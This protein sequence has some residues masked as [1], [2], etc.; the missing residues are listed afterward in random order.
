MITLPDLQIISA[1]AL[2]RSS[3][4]KGI[5]G[6]P[7]ALI[8]GKP[9]G[10]LLILA[11]SG[12]GDALMF[13]PALRLL[14]S[15]WPD[16]QIDMLT[17]FK[18]TADLYKRNPD[19]SNV[20]YWNFLKEN[21]FKSLQFVLSLHKKYLY[22]I[23]A[24][25]ANRWPYAVISR[26]ISAK[27]RLGHTYLHVDKKEL[28]FLNNYRI[29]E[30]DSLH[31]SEENIRL[32]AYLG[33]PVPELLPPLQIHLNQQD[34]L[35][36][37]TWISQHTG[38]IQNRRL[39]GIH[40]GSAIFKNQINKRWD[41]RKYAQ[42]AARLILEQHAF[43]LLFGGPEELELNQQIMAELKA[44]QADHAALIVQMPDIM[45]SIAL[46]QQCALFLS[47]DSGLMHI[48]AALQIP[49]ISIFGYTSHIHTAPWMNTKAVIIRRDLE[50][51]PCFYFSPK[52]A[53]CQFAGSP[54]EFH[55]IRGIGPDDIYSQAV[56]MLQQG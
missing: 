16:L 52:P 11:M 15:A 9:R 23:T 5:P 45:G 43:I 13:S 31:N 4:E 6:I 39:V 35:S 47:N 20:L 49:L 28:N 42:V 46:M 2:H 32:A 30:D 14:R 24:F 25:P 26:L 17:M 54:K 37:S 29:P 19:L 34:I 38:R 21:P 44:Q 1:P 22:S 51:S 40:A 56:K 33:A 8:K 53:H 27:Y 7:E 3:V 18:G 10:P 55:C 36:A 48:A 12:I 50:C 41:F